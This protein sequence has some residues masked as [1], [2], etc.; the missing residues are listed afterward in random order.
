MNPNPNVN[1]YFGPGPTVGGYGYHT[2]PSEYVPTLIQHIC[3]S[4]SLER[5][6][7]FLSI[8][9]DQFNL[10]W[11]PSDV[12]V[13]LHHPALSCDTR[14]VLGGGTYNTPF[15]GVLLLR[16]YTRIETDIEGHS[17]QNLDDL[18]LGMYN[19]VKR[20]VTAL[21]MWPGVWSDNTQTVKMLRRPMRLLPTGIEF[22]PKTD[23]KNQRWSVAY[24][25]WEVSF[26]ADLNNP[27]PINA[28]L[29]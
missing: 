27:Y 25:H 1:P 28:P 13:A 9:D 19:T 6:A 4:T 18:V 12:F 29:P 21:Q 7:V 10:K 8:F 3:N 23:E 14:D 17:R 2:W 15:D 22:H 11:P 26:V 24:T 16:I 20:I 5:R